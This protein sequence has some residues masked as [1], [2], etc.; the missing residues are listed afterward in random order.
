VDIAPEMAPPKSS[1]TARGSGNQS[2]SGTRRRSG[3]PMT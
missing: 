3:I 1:R 2:G